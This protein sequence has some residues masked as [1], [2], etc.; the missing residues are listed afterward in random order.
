MITRLT[1]FAHLRLVTM[2]EQ[3]W[4]ALVV[5]VI[6]FAEQIRRFLARAPTTQSLS[7]TAYPSRRG[8]IGVDLDGTL[9]KYH[10]WKGSEHIGDPVP[11]MLSRVKLWVTEGKE[12]R[13][14]TARVSH[15]TKGKVAARAIGDWCEKHGLP[16]LPVTNIKDFGMIELWDDRV[17][18]IEVNSGKRVDGGD[19]S[20]LVWLSALLPARPVPRA[21]KDAT[22]ARRRSKKPRRR[23]GGS[24]LIKDNANWP[25]AAQSNDPSPP[26]P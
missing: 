1:R 17:V 11:A 14:F 26:Q 18:Q 20:L 5:V 10:G 12:V 19:L 23:R 2:A 16:R 15:P 4:G 22:A 3:G 25:T 6:G 9:A 7:W 24:R 13:I 21:A 8:W